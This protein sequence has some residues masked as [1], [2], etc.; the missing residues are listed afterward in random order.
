MPLEA[1]RFVL[2]IVRPT[3]TVFDI[4]ANVGKFCRALAA[5]SW[6]IFA[7][8]PNPLVSHNI[9][10][11]AAP[12]LRLVK[13][14]L[15][16]EPVEKLQM[17]VDP[18]FGH[19][20]TSALPEW[21]PAASESFFT[22]ATTFDAFCEESQAFPDIVKLDAEGATRA[23]LAGAAKHIERKTCLFIIESFQTRPDDLLAE[24]IFLERGYRRKQISAIDVVFAPSWW[25]KERSLCF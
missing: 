25:L 21:C 20:A 19:E 5:R 2:P 22:S 4:G 23:I 6:R 16:S 17:W 9:E 7:F 15:W 1:L 10:K 3:D 11:H 24:E 14:A 8:E 13:Q 12:N 18:S